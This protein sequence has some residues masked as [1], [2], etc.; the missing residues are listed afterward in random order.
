MSN[1][2]IKHQNPDSREFT[3]GTMVVNLPNKEALQSF[4]VLNAEE[5]EIHFGFS[6]CHP[7]DQ[8]SKKR[9]LEL[10][11]EHLFDLSFRVKNIENRD[12]RYVYHLESQVKDTF[13]YITSFELGVSYIRSSPHTRLEYAVM[14][15]GLV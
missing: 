6:L 3:R 14:E 12:G 11:I 13:G 15:H 4:S 1:V 10:A 7:K 8:F 5:V 9:G 2:A